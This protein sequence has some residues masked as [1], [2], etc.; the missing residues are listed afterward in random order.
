LNCY[1]TAVAA[2]R[3]WVARVVLLPGVFQPREP[4]RPLRPGVSRV[5]SRFMLR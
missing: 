2:T 5:N 4:R 1:G 3:I